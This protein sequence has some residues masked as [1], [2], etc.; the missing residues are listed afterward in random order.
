MALFRQAMFEEIKSNFRVCS[1]RPS[2]SAVAYREQMLGLFF[3]TYGKA[4]RIIITLLPNGNWEDDTCVE[5]YPPAEL[6]VEHVDVDV[7]ADV[8][9]G[10]MLKALL[11]SILKLFATHHWTGFDIAVDQCGGMDCCHRLGRR[12]A[13]R[14]LSYFDTKQSQ[15]KPTATQATRLP[16][17]GGPAPK[18][19]QDQQPPGGG[20]EP[21]TE[22]IHVEDPVARAAGLKK[23]EDWAAVNSKRREEVEQYWSSDP[24]WFMI[25]CR[26]VFTPLQKMQAKFKISAAAWET[27]QRA[28]VARKVM[29]GE[30]PVGSRDYRL[31]VCARN[32]E[33]LTCRVSLMKLMDDDKPVWDG[34]LDNQPE[35]MTVHARQLGY[36]M[37]T[38]MMVLLQEHLLQPHDGY[39]WQTLLLPWKPALA[40]KIT[41]DCK[42]ADACEG[43]FVDPW[44]LELFREFPSAEL[45]QS[46]KCTAVI[47][48]AL[49]LTNVDT[50]QLEALHATIRRLIMMASVHTHKR[51]FED[52]N[53]AWMMVTC[54]RQHRQQEAQK[55]AMG[56]KDP[57][58]P[59]C[60]K[61]RLAMSG[62]GPVAKKRARG[63]GG[64]WRAYVRQRLVG[65]GV[66]HP[67]EDTWHDPFGRVQGATT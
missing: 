24:L 14:W 30:S 6:D 29:K 27:R 59:R 42:C 17:E 61:K 28:K 51:S 52:V 4:S 5:F 60:R 37:T 48:L 31:L 50:S 32:D 23:E 7:V 63:G 64:A 49:H 1:G 9:A 22:D 43:E 21:K 35:G 47:V 40:E 55:K 41:R 44:T 65:C 58:K 10:A 66:K 15:A 11:P 53:A 26:M 45:L 67:F 57:S 20:V 46:K 56:I 25:I 8:F 34:L 16:L 12:T 2:P 54:R 13:K 19:L 62:G 38:R 36:R 3:S 33:E 39:F 18:P